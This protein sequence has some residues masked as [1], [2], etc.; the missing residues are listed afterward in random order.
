MD[1]EREDQWSLSSTVDVSVQHED[2]RVI[3]QHPVFSALC[4]VSGITTWL[5]LYHI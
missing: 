5:L 4:R 3:S 1:T 2:Q